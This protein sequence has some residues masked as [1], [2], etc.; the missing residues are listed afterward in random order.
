MRWLILA[1]VEAKYVRITAVGGPGVGNYQ[2]TGIPTASYILRELR[3]YLQQAPILSLSYPDGG[4]VLARESHSWDNPAKFGSRT[5]VDGSGLTGDVHNVGQDFTYWYA[6]TADIPGGELIEPWS[7]FTFDEVYV[8]GEM[9]VWNCDE[10]A[11]ESGRALKGVKVEYSEVSN[12][13][14]PGDWTVLLDGTDSGE[15]WHKS[16]N[17]QRSD[18]VDFAGAGARHVRITAVGGYGVGNYGSSLGYVLNELRFYHAGIYQGFKAGDPVPADGDTVNLEVTLGWTAGMDAVTGQ[19]VWFGPAGNMTKVASNLAAEVDEIYI[20]ILDNLT[21]YEWRVDGLD[22]VVTAEGDVWSFDTKAWLWWNPGGM[23]VVGAVSTMGEGGTAGVLAVDQSGMNG[24]LHDSWAWSNEWY[25]RKP[26]TVGVTEPVL[27]VEFDR[28]YELSEMWVWNHDGT[29]PVESPIA[30]KTI[31]LEYSTDGVNYNTLMNGAEQYFILPHGN[32]DGT[33]DTVIDWGSVDAKYVRL[34]AVGGPG[35]GNYGSTEWGYKLRELRFY[36]NPGLKG[37]LDGDGDVDID[38]L[39]LMA[40]DWLT[41]EGIGCTVRPGGDA[42]GDCFVDMADFAM[43]SDE[44]M[45]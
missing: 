21:T 9:W 1:G 20:G 31:H 33:H 8:L 3:F 25:C 28:I 43:I 15:V 45:P 34:T 30:L 13:D 24:D 40:G 41:G 42:S 39:A 12:P 22:G 27:D 6:R 44:W 36:Y 14:E 7:W 26:W 4:V 18:T 19:D 38:D 2:S 37:D 17:G 29:T 32:T 23:G 5:T 16:V 35:V 10:S 11:N